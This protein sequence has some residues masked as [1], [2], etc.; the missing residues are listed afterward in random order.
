MSARRG[1]LPLARYSDPGGR[2]HLVVLR[3]RLVLDITAAG[4]ARVVAE[5]S[6]EEGTDQARAV[7]H[8]EGGYLE[9][10]RRATAPLARPL[11]AEDLRP[12]A[13]PGEATRGGDAVADGEG[14]QELAA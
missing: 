10:A 11:R 13:G 8:G 3:A 2:A 1:N 12:P 5:L 9:R 14:E 7:L 4:P 6:G